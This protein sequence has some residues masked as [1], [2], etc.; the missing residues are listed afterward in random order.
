MRR[1]LGLVSLR[2]KAQCHRIR[3]DDFF[4]ADPEPSAR[5]RVRARRA[6]ALGA[7]GKHDS[8]AGT[9]PVHQ[10]LDPVAVGSSSTLA[11]MLRSASAPPR[12]TPPAKDS[13]AARGPDSGPDSG[14]VGQA[15]PGC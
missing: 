15:L 9:S 12:P 2:K 8:P 3:K 7:R 10:V 11:G 5:Y 14:R 1:R 13:H 6:S 4:F